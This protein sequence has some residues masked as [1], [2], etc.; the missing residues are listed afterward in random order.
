MKSRSSAL[1]A[2][3]VSGLFC[4]CVQTTL[5]VPEDHPA[6]PDY[7]VASASPGSAFS[8]DETPLPAATAAHDEHSHH[9]HHHP[10]ETTPDGGA[11]R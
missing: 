3:V 4:A 1:L 8:T 2:V 10:D 9:H 11:R 5:D 6:S 7:P